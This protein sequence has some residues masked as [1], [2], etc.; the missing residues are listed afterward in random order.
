MIVRQAREH[1][2]R[3]LREA[4]AERERLI[5][6]ASGEGRE[7]G[8]REGYAAGLARGRDEGRKIAERQARD[9]IAS[10]VRVVTGAGEALERAHA[11]LLGE[12]REELLSFAVEMA[13]AIA[14]RALRV[15]PTLVVDAV[16]DALERIG[17]AQTVSITLHPDDEAIVRT[18]MPDLIA[19]LRERSRVE[20][21]HDRS[22]ERGSCVVRG[23]HGVLADATLAT[24]IERIAREILP[25]GPRAQVAA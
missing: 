2:E 9:E 25:D 10:A 5:A 15:D 18:S 7:A 13:S 20:F 11:E 24:R 14:R 8:E 21:R 6:S 17:S 1:A 23:E 3:I 4:R 16:R 19:A 22:L 12:A